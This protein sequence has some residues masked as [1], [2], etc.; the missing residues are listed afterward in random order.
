MVPTI[1]GPL[2]PNGLKRNSLAWL[3]SATVRQAGISPRSA[4][5]YRQTMPLQGR[6]QRGQMY[7]PDYA[8]PYPIFQIEGRTF[9]CRVDTDYSVDEITIPGDPNPADVERAFFCQGE[10]FMVQQPGDLVKLPQWWDGV[11]MTRSRGANNAGDLPLPYTFTVPPIGQAALVTMS[12]PYAGVTNQ[13]F[14]IGGFRYRQV[15]PNQRYTAATVIDGASPAYVP[16]QVVALSF[17][18]TLSIPAIVGSGP[19]VLASSFSRSYSTL[20]SPPMA[21]TPANNVFLQSTTVTPADQFQAIN[22]VTTQN[23]SGGPLYT[24]ATVNFTFTPAP[25]AAPGANQVWLQ[26][27]D[28]P[29]TGSGITTNPGPTQLPSGESMDY[30]MGRMWIGAGREYVAG[31]IVGGPSGH[32]AYDYRDSILYM[33]ENAYTVGGGAFIVPSNAGNIRCLRHPANIDT[34]LGEG[35]LKVFTRKSVYSVNVSPNRAD[36]AALEEP[37]QRVE[38]INYGAMGDDAVVA[39]NG[40]LYYRSVDGVRTLLQGIRYFGQPGNTPISREMSRVIDQDNKE[41]L[42]M[43]SGILVDNRLL[44]TCQPYQ[45]PYGVAHKGVMALNF[46]LIS[47]MAEKLPPAWEG[48]WEGLN[49]MQLWQGD[50]GGRERA[51]AMV[52]SEAG[53]LEIWELIN[54]VLF[55]QNQTGE[56]RITWAAETP[57]YTFDKVFML[58]EL[59]TM[60]MWMDRIIGTVD[61]EVYVRPDQYPCWT[62]WANWQECSARNECELP[63]PPVPCDYPQ[64]RYQ[65]LYRATVTLPKPPTLC[66]QVGPTARPMNIGYAFQ[67]KI[68]VKGYC[69]I[70]GLLLHAFEREKQPYQNLIC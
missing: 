53:Q 47:N 69:R 15:L 29:N 34:A 70:R 11:N 37:I 25:L 62:L 14:T 33:T 66:A 36:W 43:C 68:V 63:Q 64:Q 65:P 6:F 49:V 40:D 12:G 32:V 26:N 23:L 60:E 48:V 52:Y 17:P 19:A 24:W 55:D 20:G 3:N 56:A 46:D 44:M 9:R 35:Q 61:F 42:H 7:Q 58:K 57:S 18:E 31:D 13:V 39:V 51:F 45:T 54:G 59:D 4:W 1:A 16:G 50:F 8:Y 27:L 22:Y 28:N 21:S 10:Q 5:V 67:V 38:Q 41:L 30:Y 2:N